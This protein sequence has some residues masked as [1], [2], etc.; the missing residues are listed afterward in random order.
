MSIADELLDW[1]HLAVGLGLFGRRRRVPTDRPGRPDLGRDG[2]APAVGPTRRPS[3]AAARRREAGPQRRLSARLDRV[4][5]ARGGDAPRRRRRR[6]PA[7]RRETSGTR[8]SS[9]SGPVPPASRQPPRGRCSTTGL[10]RPAFGAGASAGRRG[11]LRRLEQ[12]GQVGGVAGDGGG[13]GHHL[14][15]HDLEVL[16][17]RACPWPRRPSRSRRWRGW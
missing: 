12:P 14:L 5:R 17:V 10:G 4:A 6:A 11:S 2:G 1:L 3:G 13:G 8:S 16:V 7:Q 9:S 15:G